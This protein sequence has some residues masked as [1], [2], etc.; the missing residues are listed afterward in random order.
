MICCDHYHNNDPSKTIRRTFTKILTMMAIDWEN[1][2]IDEVSM[3]TTT[4]NANLSRRFNNGT[5]AIYTVA[6]M[7]HCSH[8]FANDMDEKASNTSLR[9]L[10]MN[11]DLPFD[12]SKTLVYWPIIII[13]F[14]HLM[15]CA[16]INGMLNTLLI[17]LVS[18]IV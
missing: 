14:I 13:Q 9:P 5:V 12:F 18:F 4:Y 16:Y 17:N 10:I 7:F 1:R 11:M 2:A 15:L 6:V 3:I 8:L